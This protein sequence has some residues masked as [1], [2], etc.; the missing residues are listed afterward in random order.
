MLT[1]PNRILDG[2]QFVDLWKGV[3]EG[4]YFCSARTAAGIARKVLESVEFVRASQAERRKGSPGSLAALT[5][6]DAMVDSLPADAEDA[7][8]LLKTSCAGMGL[9]DGRNVRH[10]C[11]ELA[12]VFG[13]IKQER[14]SGKQYKP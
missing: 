10:V 3:R 1:E 8:A 2:S 7:A 14:E 4:E 12:L 13:K 6:I 9:P 11:D 5:C